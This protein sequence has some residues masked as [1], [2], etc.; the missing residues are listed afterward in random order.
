MGK[1]EQAFTIDVAAPPD[2]AYDALKAAIQAMDG[3]H[4][5]AIDD[6]GRTLDFSTGV[7]LTSWGEELQATVLEGQSGGSR[8]E[9]RGKPKGTFLTTKWGED[10]HAKTVEKRLRSE[11][12]T[13]MT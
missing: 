2:Q 1:Y 13:A 8:V 11:L 7:S 4:M 6:S 5:G 9:V 3:G 10:V 12:D